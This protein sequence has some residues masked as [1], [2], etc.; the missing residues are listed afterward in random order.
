MHLEH[1]ARVLL[2]AFIFTMSAYALFV[3]AI[4]LKSHGRVSGM[5]RDL[6]IW[7]LHGTLVLL[8]ALLALAA[9]V[10]NDPRLITLVAAAAVVDYFVRRLVTRTA[11]GAE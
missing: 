11:D 4:G 8:A 10:R 2:V 5:R 3:F 6:V 9:F 1:L 7:M